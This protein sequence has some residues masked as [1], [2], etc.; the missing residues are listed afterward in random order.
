V[1]YI[2][3]CWTLECGSDP[4]MTQ[5]LV[6]SKLECKLLSTRSHQIMFAKLVTG[7]SKISAADVLAKMTKVDG[8]L[9]PCW[10]TSSLISIFRRISAVS[11]MTTPFIACLTFSLLNNRILQLQS[12]QRCAKGIIYNEARTLHYGI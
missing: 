8:K 1:D 9:T 4:W 10:W 6:N 3:Q 2:D 5:D 11:K 7:C 12:L